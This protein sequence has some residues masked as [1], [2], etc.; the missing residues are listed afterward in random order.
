MAT[1]HST[2]R[3]ST[4]LCLLVL[5]PEADRPRLNPL[6]QLRHVLV[7]HRGGLGQLG[8]GAAGGDEEPLDVLHQDLGQPQDVLPLPREA[9]VPGPVLGLA[10]EAVQGAG[11]G[12]HDRGVEAH[13]DS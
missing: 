12:E 7:R 8:P 5:G 3:V 4:Y 10:V 9:E 2:H 11:R 1:Q 13:Q 6:H